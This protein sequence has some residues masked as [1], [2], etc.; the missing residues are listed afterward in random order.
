M[1]SVVEDAGQRLPV[2]AAAD[3]TTALGIVR[4]W[5]RPPT[6]DRRTA[7]GAR[8][9]PS[10]GGVDAD[11]QERRRRRRR[12]RRPGL[13]CLRPAAAEVAR[14]RRLAVSPGE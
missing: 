5:V 3:G 4:M 10:V 14:S 6:A 13:V 8:R 12:R 11:E 9:R 1:I 7:L 2:S